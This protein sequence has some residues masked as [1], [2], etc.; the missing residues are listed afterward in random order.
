MCV[1]LKTNVAIEFQSNL[2]L[3]LLDYTANKKSILIHN[4][5]AIIIFDYKIK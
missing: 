4:I 5:D 2:L 3:L 1:S